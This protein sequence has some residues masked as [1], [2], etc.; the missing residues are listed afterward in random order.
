MNKESARKMINRLLTIGFLLIIVSFTLFIIS[1]IIQQMIIFGIGIITIS[2][3]F[4]SW[5]IAYYFMSK[6]RLLGD[7][8]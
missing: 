6:L 1:I 2:V 3:A 8:E 7:E 5:V 4:V